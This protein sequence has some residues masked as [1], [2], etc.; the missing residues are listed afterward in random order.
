MRESCV[1]CGAALATGYRGRPRV[2]CS[3]E[4]FNRRRAIRARNKTRLV[5]ASHHVL[6][7]VAELTPWPDLQL[8]LTLLV[9]VLNQLDDEVTSS[10]M[11]LEHP[12]EP[13]TPEKVPPEEVTS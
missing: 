3:T 6:R 10:Q 7:A 1:V 8:E 2:T 9:G 12:A 4:C 5:G 11:K 13:V